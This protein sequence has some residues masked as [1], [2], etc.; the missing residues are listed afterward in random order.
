MF[1]RASDRTPLQVSADDDEINPHF[2]VLVPVL[3]IGCYLL[4]GNIETYHLKFKQNRRT[5]NII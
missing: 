4:R 5:S 2:V 3:Q 1:E